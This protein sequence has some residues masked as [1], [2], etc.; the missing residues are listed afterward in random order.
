MSHLVPE[1]EIL[2]RSS[3]L[4]LGAFI[5]LVNRLALHAGQWSLSTYWTVTPMY[6]TACLRHT[7]HRLSARHHP[8][9]ATSL[10]TRNKEQSTWPQ[11]LL[12]AVRR[13]N[14]RNRSIVFHQA[15]VY[16]K[17]P[18][19]PTQSSSSLRI[20]WEQWL[21]I[22]CSGNSFSSFILSRVWM[23]THGVWVGNPIYW[24]FTL[25]TTNTYDSLTELHTPKITVTTAHI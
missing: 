7:A 8:I 5:K 21:C 6:L 19:I 22:N 24:T 12:S 9:H 13:G 15:T 25:V 2:L 3:S 11:A 4:Q 17:S 20:N 18:V 23:I 16:C 1:G 14:Y 10:K